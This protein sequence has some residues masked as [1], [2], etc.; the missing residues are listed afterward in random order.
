M[1]QDERPPRAAEVDVALTIRIPHVGTFPPFHEQGR[2][3][4]GTER[5]H[6]R[7][8]PAGKQ[9]PG[10]LEERRT[11]GTGVGG[12]RRGACRHGS[13]FRAKLAPN[14]R[15]LNPDNAPDSPPMPPEN[16]TWPG[17]QA[18]LDKARALDDA[19]PLA[20]F[21]ARFLRVAFNAIS[22]I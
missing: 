7:I 14:P 5:P 13:R 19:D 11:F 2:P 1:A 17:H 22:S 15:A 12:R 3:A 16:T 9:R 6:G 10:F 20:S 21:R 8:H 18:F 4:Y